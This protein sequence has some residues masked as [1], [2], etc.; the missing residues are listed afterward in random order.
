MSIRGVIISVAAN[1]IVAGA[2]WF[3]KG[4]NF[5]LVCLGI[6][7]L[8]LAIGLFWPKKPQPQIPPPPSLPPLVTTSQR[9]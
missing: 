8:L 5:G 6:G 3:I 2:V 9:P 4:P 7:F 1:F